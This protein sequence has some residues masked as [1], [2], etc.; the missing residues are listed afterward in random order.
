MY[1]LAISAA[2]LAH[3]EVEPDD[4]RHEDVPAA[5]AALAFVCVVRQAL[6]IL[7]TM[8]ATKGR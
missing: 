3:F 4:V 1:A 5:T 2:V 6:R 7:L 8:R